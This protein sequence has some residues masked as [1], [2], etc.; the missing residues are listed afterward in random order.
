MKKLFYLAIV[1]VM[2]ILASCS[3]NDGYRSIVP[4]TAKVVMR[5]DYKA[6]YSQTGIDRDKLKAG[7]M[8]LVKD[9]D[10]V[11]GVDAIGIDKDAPFYGF[12]DESV[13]SCGSCGMVFR[14]SDRK[15]LEAFIAEKAE[16]EADDVDG[17]TVYAPNDGRELL[18]GVSDEALLILGP[19]YD[20]AKKLKKLLVSML[21]HENADND[22]SD[23]EL[24]DRAEDAD[25]IVSLYGDLS[26]VP[27]AAWN[28]LRRNLAETGQEG[29]LDTEALSTMTYGIDI[30][31]SDNILNANFW[32]KSSDAE[33]QKRIENMTDK[34]VSDDAFGLFT[35]KTVLGFAL[36][37]NGKSVVELA[38]PQF[39]SA[40]NAMGEMAPMFDVVLKLIEIVDGNV[41]FGFDDVE[42]FDGGLAI[43]TTGDGDAL[44]NAMTTLGLPAPRKD[45]GKLIFGIEG[46]PMNM[47][48]DG[49]LFTA[50]M[51]D[52]VQA[53][54]SKSSTMN[55][56]LKSQLKDHSFTMF[57]NVNASI[58]QARKNGIIDRQAQS[59]LDAIK[60]ITDNVH[61]VTLTL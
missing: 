8:E 10:I 25:A 14:V 45:N 60:E 37:L 35:D 50:T 54:I 30:K 52:D 58:E 7:I 3:G 43:M 56:D 47:C 1:A 61:Y 15:L 23:N 38:E 55:G 12:V 24:F 29:S 27:D 49:K 11:V 5:I 57:I 28:F 53:R 2:T 4:Q 36:A 21:K 34:K 39:A 16:L 22:P 46:M 13:L 6:L 20:D 17:I 33:T 59:V 42:N 41:L 48:L 51:G 9:E 44:T 26:V 40:R 32:C 19:A 31:A 18:I